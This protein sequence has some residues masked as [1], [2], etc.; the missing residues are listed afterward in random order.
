MEPLFNA[1]TP[2]ESL[3]H[4]YNNGGSGALDYFKRNFSAGLDYGT[5]HYIERG[6]REA[7]IK[8]HLGAEAAYAPLSEA[9]WKQGPYFRQGMVWTPGLTRAGAEVNADMHDAR[10]VRDLMSAQYSGPGHIALAL[11]GQFVAGAMDP[12]NFVPL[13]GEMGA[14]VRG[15]KTA[16]RMI[17]RAG[18]FGAAEN[19]A[20]AAVQA[21]FLHNVME[22]EGS[23]YGMSEAMQ[24][25]AAA[26][27][28]GGTI[29]GIRGAVHYHY[30]V[31]SRQAA[32]ATRSLLDA[33]SQLHEKDVFD[34][35]LGGQ[36]AMAQAAD[37]STRVGQEMRAGLEKTMLDVAGQ[38]RNAREAA[39]RI[40]QAPDGSMPGA[41]SE[42]AS[43]RAQGLF[44]RVRSMFGGGDTDG[45]QR[46]HHADALVRKNVA[47]AMG[48]VEKRA[49]DAAL[50]DV[51]GRLEEV[52]SS[53]SGVAKAVARQAQDSLDRHDAIM[54]R[55]SAVE[56]KLRQGQRPERLE[57][58]QI[59]SA[60]RDL[61]EQLDGLREEIRRARQ[62]E[63]VIPSDKEPEVT[64]AN[65]LHD[66]V[67][68]A[69]DAVVP[70]PLRAEAHAVA[71]ASL[72]PQPKETG[73]TI[74]AAE[75]AE[76]AKLM[77]QELAETE[78]AADAMHRGALKSL[79][80][81]LQIRRA[82]RD[83]K[84]P[85]F[86]EAFSL[87]Q[88]AVLRLPE[89]VSFVK[90]KDGSWALARVKDN[91]QGNRVFTVAG[92]KAGSFDVSTALNRDRAVARLASD[93]QRGG[94]TREQLASLLRSALFDRD[95]N[96]Y[97]TEFQAKVGKYRGYVIAERADGQAMLLHEDLVDAANRAGLGIIQTYEPTRDAIRD[98][99]GRGKLPVNPI[100]MWDNWKD[101]NGE[102]VVRAWRDG[103]DKMVSEHP[104]MDFP[105]EIRKGF[106]DTV[107]KFAGKDAADAV[108]SVL[109]EAR[110]FVPD[111]A[112]KRDADEALSQAYTMIRDS[113]SKII[114]DV[115]GQ[116]AEGWVPGDAARAF[117]AHVEIE[118]LG[119]VSKLSKVERESLKA[120]N[121]EMAANPELRERVFSLRDAALKEYEA[122]Y[123]HV[124]RAD[125]QKQFAGSIEVMHSAARAQLELE[126]MKVL[127]R[128]AESKW[129][130]I[131][132]APETGEIPI[133]NERDLDTLSYLGRRAFEE[134]RID[135]GNIR[136]AEK[137][138]AE[139]NRALVAL[140]NKRSV[141]AVRGDLG[142]LSEFDAQNAF[143]EYE[144]FEGGGESH[145]WID[146]SY[147]QNRLSPFDTETLGRISE[148]WSAEEDRLQAKLTAATDDAARANA[149]AQL[150]QARAGRDAVAREMA[151]R[152]RTE[153]GRGHEVNPRWET[154]SPRAA[155]DL[156]TAAGMDDA[157][158]RTFDLSRAQAEEKVREAGMPRPPDKVEA[159]RIKAVEE[160]LD[161]MEQGIDP[162]YGNEDIPPMDFMALSRATAFFQTAKQVGENIT[163]IGEIC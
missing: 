89:G 53:L 57:V 60:L 132:S 151:Q 94:I 135:P 155:E 62:M 74:T 24:D 128:T 10:R 64:P 48:R 104:D 102:L 161:Y 106:V 61:K 72:G 49:A 31:R 93:M 95:V 163:K 97:I 140:A 58:D 80:F 12:L 6:M 111:G 152:T 5:P 156:H 96:S 98:L 43:Q 37:L 144:F 16:T 92:R 134:K 139:G 33:M 154:S 1:A 124:V 113:H 127:N 133:Y 71:D 131:M 35:D 21:P 85:R 159:E 59:T 138:Q 117:L 148:Y 70:E 38:D 8:A 115:I 122:A 129:Q 150:I 51:T 149:A 103:W 7:V 54:D 137:L 39:T 56:D 107:R 82:L 79:G 125:S 143:R 44:Q 50:A 84:A 45:G 66:P 22:Q 67:K 69:I 40:F 121:A 76:A 55:I 99:Y 157:A 29:G 9:E 30:N 2:Q 65:V 52:D 81:L 47:E 116:H 26:A 158:R 142:R 86:A 68:Q 46:I 18:A 147:K 146:K 112:L 136:H 87:A 32:D 153:P 123:E 25:I 108:N 14:W 3:A 126:V 109:K 162:F 141:E 83:T 17:A 15:A 101:V 75:K 118:E 13:V 73:P 20:Q 28:L 36:E 4:F 91:A 105:K 23:E 100:S 114:G 42:N 11:G 160:Y 120:L 90:T 19:I 119:F 145:F 78:G 77:Q 110:R 27:V 88:D 34:V 63:P 41:L 130:E